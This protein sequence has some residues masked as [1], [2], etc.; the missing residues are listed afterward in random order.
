MDNGFFR[1]NILVKKKKKY[2]W[3]IKKEK[4]NKKEKIKIRT[5]G[6]LVPCGS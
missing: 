1:A 2:K 4:E 5:W 3:A 6:R